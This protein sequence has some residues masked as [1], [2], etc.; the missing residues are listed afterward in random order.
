MVYIIMY[1]KPMMTRTQ[2]YLTDEQINRLKRMA[3]EQKTTMS[4]ILRRI[5]AE[6]MVKYNKKKLASSP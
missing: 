2:I 5:L 1:V 4:E 6:D 3:F